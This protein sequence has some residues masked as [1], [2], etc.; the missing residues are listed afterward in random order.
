MKIEDGV[1]ESVAS[2]S[3]LRAVED[4][5]ENTANATS[6]VSKVAL[7]AVVDSSDSDSD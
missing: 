6:A 7:S 3:L 1:L 4:E 5:G 2:E